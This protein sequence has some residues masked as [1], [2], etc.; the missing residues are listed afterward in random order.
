MYSKP[1]TNTLS[2]SAFYDFSSTIM[3]NNMNLKIVSNIRTFGHA[4]AAI[5]SNPGLSF[6]CFYFSQPS[7]I[8]L[9]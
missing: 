4:V 6:L 9:G 7:S 8:L 3:T 5:M 1:I 2:M